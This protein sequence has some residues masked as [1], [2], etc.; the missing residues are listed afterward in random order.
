MIKLI[1]N[2]T[3]NTIILNRR[4]LQSKRLLKHS[5]LSISEIAYEVGFLEP[6]YFCKV[7]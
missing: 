1:S 3:L 4:L 2:T 7:F 6:S 5:D